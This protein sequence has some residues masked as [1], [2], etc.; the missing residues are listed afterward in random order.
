MNRAYTP[1]ESDRYRILVE[2]VTDYA[3]YMLDP[4]GIVSSW[5]AG[6]QRFKGYT[7]DE[8]IGQHFS[9]FYT[10]DDRASGLPARA[11]EISA[12]EG[13]FEAEGWRMRKDG[14]RFWA[15]VVIDPIR[16]SS[17]ALTGFAKVTR[18]LTERRASE[19]ALRQS[20]EQFRLLVQGVTDYA[21]YMLSPEG[22]VTNW[23]PGAQRIK[24]YTPVEIVGKH[25]SQFYTPEDR[26]AGRPERALRTAAEEGKFEAE[27]WRLRK[28]GSRFWSHVIIDPIRDEQGKLIGFAKITR[29]AT[30][31]K[32]AQDS[33][34][35][36]REA[37]FQSQKMDAIGQLTGGV[38]HDFNNL[39]MAVLGS[40]ELLR[41]RMPD[42]PAQLRLVDNAIQGARRGATLTQR[43]LSFARR[44]EMDVVPLNVAAL[45]HG[46]S[47]LLD[48]TLGKDVE[49]QTDF[50]QA[51]GPAVADDNQLELALLN[52]C[53]NARDAMKHGGNIV[54]AGR[55]EDVDLRHVSGLPP[56]KYVCLSV[57][58]TGE[59]MDAETLARAS[60]PFFTT[61][62]VG[63][64]TGLG[65]SMV[66]GMAEQMGGR[67]LIRS[68]LGEGTT[69]EIWLASATAAAQAQDAPTEAPAPQAGPRKLKVLAVDDDRL[70]LFNTVAMLEDLGHEAVEAGSGVE[71]LELLAQ[72]SFDLVITD[73]SMPRMSGTQLMDAI[74]QDWPGTKM[75]LATGY[76]ELPG[77]VEVKVPRLG[78][79]FNE[80]DLKKVL[81]G[82]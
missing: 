30:E 28:D 39:L 45:V 1:E 19:E 38:A 11:L 10:A 15:H 31:R 64:G 18:D 67:L 81:A 22:I 29:D 68:T 13:K 37:L 20:Q 53:V 72:Q 8:I 78:K 42:D 76:A 6:A 56:G 50:P 52:L 21:I 24:G 71:A 40:L 59:G 12:R 44:Q 69:A 9:R 77:G 34:E 5:N 80:H 47:D 43:M 36:A 60:E 75:I 7:P 62:G 27:G 26:A 82:L 41:K 17:G 35:R 54:I 25:F 79:P 73:Q 2:A 23:N 70:V 58:D 55:E 32:E 46:M 74:A 16:D 14:T 48:R 63:K 33:L 3:I 66:H 4:A 61:K 51:L 65:L 57:T 49:I